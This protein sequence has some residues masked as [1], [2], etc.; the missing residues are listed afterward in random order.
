[1]EDTTVYDS[2]LDTTSMLVDGELTSGGLRDVVFRP[3]RLTPRERDT[4]VSRVKAALGN[5]PVTNALV[6]IVANPWTWMMVLFSPIGGESLAVGWNSVARNVSPYLRKESGLLAKLGALTSQ[7]VLRGTDV[8]AAVHRMAQV[9]RERLDAPWRTEFN[10]VMDSFLA[11]HGLDPRNGLNWTRYGEG[12]VERLKAREIALGMQAKL[13]RMDE[14]VER[15]RL[16]SVGKK[17][18]TKLAQL[19]ERGKY[20][21][22]IRLGLQDIPYVEEAILPAGSADAILAKYDGLSDMVGAAR[23]MFTQEIDAV[24]PDKHAFYN[25]MR[26]MGNDRIREKGRIVGN[27]AATGT[28]VVAGYEAALKKGTEAADRYLDDAYATWRS[29]IEKNGPGYFPRNQ[30]EQWGPRGPINNEDLLDFRSFAPAVRPGGS[31]KS[32]RAM[33]GRNFHPDDW[34]D[35]AEVFGLSEQGAQAAARSQSRFEALASGRGAARFERLRPGAS[36]TKWARQSQVT[37]AMFTADI[38]DELRAVNRVTRRT[39]EGERTVAPAVSY[40]GGGRVNTPLE[41]LE[42]FGKT[43]VPGGRFSL[44]D[45]FAANL[46]PKVMANDHARRIIGQV[47]LPH[48]MGSVG[49]RRSTTAAAISWAREMAG[50][51]ANTTAAKAMEDGGSWGKAF[52]GYLRNFAARD[53]DLAMATGFTSAATKTLYSAGL[54]FNV[55]SALMN[56]TQPFLHAG[57]WVGYKNILKGYQDVSREMGGYLAERSRQGFKAL[58][59]AEKDG[60]IRRHF[61]LADLM[62]ITGDTMAQIEKMTMTGE[63]L[64]HVP[65]SRYD[66]AIDWSLALFEKTEWMN[67]GATAHAVKHRLA[68]DGLDIAE[69]LARAT[70]R[71]VVLETQFGGHWLNTPTAFVAGGERQGLFGRLWQNPLIRQFMSFPLRAFTAATHTA[72]R[73]EGGGGLGTFSGWQQAFTGA[74][75]AMG[76]SAVMVYAARDLL[77]LDMERA[78]FASAVTDII[79]GISEGRYAKDEGLLPTPP[80]VRLLE[81]LGAGIVN[82]EGLSYFARELVGGVAP[83]GR[84]LVRISETLPDFGQR[85]YADWGNPVKG[86]DG[87]ML[88]PVYKQDGSLLHRVPAMSLVARAAGIDIDGKAAAKAERAILANRDLAIELKNRAM[89]AY[90]NGNEGELNSARGEFQKRF[91]VPLLFSQSHLRRAQESRDR[92]LEERVIDQLPREIRSQYAGAGAG[93]RE[94]RLNP[95]VVGQAAPAPQ[96]ASTGTPP[97]EAF[98]G[99]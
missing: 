3:D 90:L 62:G 69:P 53:D 55:S 32:R 77:G 45:V 9:A 10:T 72:S 42:Q 6:D 23:R 36:I 11:K 70:A 96:E 14:T 64:R 63:H 13:D 18:A 26:G 33:T 48:A 93:G 34:R 49:T 99:F 27:L 29:V 39:F 5:Q 7:Q 44:A 60:M 76:A 56:A 86:P 92:T 30:W 61:P 54:G 47:V 65:K 67:R 78:G 25:L 43:P 22:P 16:V 1:M 51:F 81:R 37:N 59:E 8:P 52:V 19:K 83:A 94:A 46:D 21:G 20:A 91:G 40:Y 2:L 15:S 57:S 28:K 87:E 74:A 17:Q 50:S 31:F 75:R 71:D 95:G 80:A 12:T 4:H 79:P 85:Q 24:V 41:T 82:D 38:G 68:Q 89:G 35:L 88:I 98:R 58:S 73:L 84:Q 97:F 66:R